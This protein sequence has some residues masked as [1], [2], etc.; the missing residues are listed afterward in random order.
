MG[1]GGG[2]R[3]SCTIEIESAEFGG[4]GYGRMPMGTLDAIFKGA[5]N[6]TK[7]ARGRA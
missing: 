4:Q 2:S 6:V 5:C 7:E 1:G 3:T